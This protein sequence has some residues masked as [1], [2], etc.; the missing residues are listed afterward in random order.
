MAE[1]DRRSVRPLTSREIAK[2]IGGFLDAVP[3]ENR[4]LS[5]LLVMTPEQVGD[6][7]RVLRDSLATQS[8]PVEATLRP[9]RPALTYLGALVH[10]L[11]TWCSVASVL[12]ALTW[13]VEHPEAIAAVFGEPPA[14]PPAP[15]PEAA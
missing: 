9:L 14:S 3:A 4:F 7:L 6:L 5:S 10:G 2:V 8:V 15:P 12:E 13:W 1:L 11:C